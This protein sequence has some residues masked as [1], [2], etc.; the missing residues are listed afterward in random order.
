MSRINLMNNDNFNNKNRS[1]NN[2][3]VKDHLSEDEIDKVEDLR[4]ELKK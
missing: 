1:R 3:F 2:S 4:P